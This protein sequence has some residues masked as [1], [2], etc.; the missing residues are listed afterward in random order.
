[1]VLV[2]SR[3]IVHV[4]P[5]LAATTPVVRAVASAAIRDRIPASIVSPGAARTVVPRVDLNDRHGR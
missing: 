1:M 4:P 3:A 2:R 5:V